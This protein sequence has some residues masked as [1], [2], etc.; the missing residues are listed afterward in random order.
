MSRPPNVTTSLSLVVALGLTAIAAGQE[1]G[2]RV[3]ADRP[4]PEVSRHMTGVCIE[5]VN[6]EIYGGIYSQMVF[7]ESFQEPPAAAVEGFASYGGAWAV[8]GGVVCAPAGDG[9]KL[10][11]GR[12]VL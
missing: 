3:R 5:D 10:V 12:P 7:G 2:I 11:A 4:G 8:E 9:P 1:A 6:H